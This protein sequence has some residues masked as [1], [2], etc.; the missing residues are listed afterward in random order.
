MYQS[1]ENARKNKKIEKKGS[2]QGSNAEDEHFTPAPDTP[3]RWFNAVLPVAFLIIT[4]ILG[5]IVTGMQKSFEM[6]IQKS[7]D[8]ANDRWGS[9]WHEIPILTDSQ[10]FIVNAGFVIGNADSFTALLWGSLTGLTVAIFLSLTQRL[11]KV[12]DTFLTMTNGFKSMIPA[13][14]ILALAWSLAK[15]TQELHTAEFIT[16]ALEGLLRPELM[17]ALV[18]VISGL[19]S[20]STGSSWSTMAILFPIALPASWTLSMQSGMSPQESTDILIITISAIMG[21]SVMGDHI[22]PISDTTIMSSLASGC[23]HVEHVRTQLPY[24]LTVGLI[25]FIFTLLSAFYA[26]NLY[27]NVLSFPIGIL[28]MYLILSKFGKKIST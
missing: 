4:T 21:A 13:L 6:L 26:Q 27:F 18:F 19:I 5:L 1:E 8:L 11:L 22:S 3:M 17:P 16:S 2:N 7:P 15:T 12:N 20:F 28:L 10:S 14:M 9:I 23:D 24:A 25:S